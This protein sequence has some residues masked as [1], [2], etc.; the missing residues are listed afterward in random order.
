MRL[1]LV[2]LALLILVPL[3]ELAVIIKVGESLGVLPTL[4]L[5]V[6]MAVLGTVLLRQQ[7]LA[8][9]RQSEQA[10]ASGQVPVES[11]LGGVGLLIAGVLMMTPGFL[12]DI[13]GLALLVPWLRRRVAGWLLA[14]LTVVGLGRIRTSPTERRQQTGRTG[15]A[16]GGKVIDGEFTRVDEA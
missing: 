6:G 13:M 3:A 16:R 4:G 9:L 12:T 7:G 2:I 1:P 10:I 11:A 5:L 14:R 8:V 15:Q